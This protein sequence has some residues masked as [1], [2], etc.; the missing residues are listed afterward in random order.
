VSDRGHDIVFPAG[1]A[2]LLGSPETVEPTDDN[3]ARLNGRLEGALSRAAPERRRGVAADLVD[4][5]RFAPSVHHAVWR[6]SD[7]KPAAVSLMRPLNTAGA[8]PG[9][10]VRRSSG[11][12][13]R[14]RP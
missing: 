8:R 13:A 7:P 14:G 4:C 6:R 1:D 2:E 5:L 11:V 10:S 9:A 12:R 3:L